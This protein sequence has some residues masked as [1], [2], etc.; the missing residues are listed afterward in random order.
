MNRSTLK[1]QAR[2]IVSSQRKPILIASALCLALTLLLTYLSSRLTLP[3]SDQLQELSQRFGERILQQDYDGAARLLASY[4]PSRLES[5][6]SELLTYLGSVVGFGFLLLLFR[7]VRGQEVAPGMLLD[8]FSTLLKVL[9]LTVLTQLILTFCLW[10]LIV[11]YF[12]ALYSYRMARYLMILHPEYGVIDCLRE[13]RLRMRGHRIE[14][15]LLDLSFLGWALLCAVPLLGLAVAV[16]VLPYWNCS[17]LLFCEAVNS[18][19]ESGAP[20]REETGIY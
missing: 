20:A 13:S 8:G 7:A 2:A 1:S 19:F 16:W 9:L 12:I 18:R 6:V 10:A 17:E 11:P 3:T 5:L 14:F 15:F 4:Q